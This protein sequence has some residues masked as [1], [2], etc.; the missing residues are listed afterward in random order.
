MSMPRHFFLV[1]HGES[2]GNV[3]NNLAK[4]GDISHFTDEFVTTPGRTWRLTDKGEG[5]VKRSPSSEITA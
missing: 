5:F 2:V 1:R 3:A 4:Q